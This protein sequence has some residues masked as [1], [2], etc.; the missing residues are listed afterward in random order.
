MVAVVSAEVILTHLAEVKVTHLGEYG[1]FLSRQN[2]DPG[3]S[4]GDSGSEQAR[5]IDPADCPGDGAIAQY[6]ASVFAREAVGAVR[7]A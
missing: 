2:A 1:G 3:A 6:G 7:A 5:A 4:C